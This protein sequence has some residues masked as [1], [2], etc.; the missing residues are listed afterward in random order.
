MTQNKQN[1]V[2][3]VIESCDFKSSGMQK[4]GK[5]PWQKFAVVING[6]NYTTFEAEYTDLVGTEGEWFFKVNEWTDK[7]GV[8]HTDKQLFAPRKKPSVPANPGQII[9]EGKLLKTIAAEVH[10]IWLAV[11][12]KQK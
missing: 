9:D 5:T 12:A 3:G 10:D 8:V 4:D 1:S 2:I 7:V 6:D 11:K